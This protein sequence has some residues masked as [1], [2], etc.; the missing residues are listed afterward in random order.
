MNILIA[1]A[2]LM[3]A[4]IGVEYALG[5]HAVACLGRRPEAVEERVSRAFDLVSSHGLAGVE[6]VAAARGRLG[7]VADLGDVAT[8]VDLVVESVVEDLAT[9]IEVLRR[10]AERFPE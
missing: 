6:A 5:G 10:C 9:K 1:G 7:V 2:G 3:G 4:Q 8:P